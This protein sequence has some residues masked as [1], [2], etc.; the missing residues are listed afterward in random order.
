MENNNNK[1]LPLPLSIS[2][3]NDNNNKEKDNLILEEFKDK[4]F[5]I[6]INNKNCEFLLINLCKIFS[7]DFKN[8]DKFQERL[9]NNM[10]LINMILVNFA[11]LAHLTKPIVKDIIYIAKEKY[12]L[13][14]KNSALLLAKIAKASEEMEQFVRNLHGIEVI[15]NIAKFIK[16]DKK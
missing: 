8:I 2:D 1:T 4:D 9:I 10:S 3:G 14:R 6:F 11:N 12:D 7:E 15:M 16:L 13:L 5:D